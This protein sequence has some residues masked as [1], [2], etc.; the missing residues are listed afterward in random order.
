MRDTETEREAETQ[1]EGEAGSM[2]GA[3][4][5][6][7]SRVSRI[8]PWAEGST[9]PLSHPGCPHVKNLLQFLGEPLRKAKQSSWIKTIIPLCTEQQQQQQKT[10]TKVFSHGNSFYTPF[11]FHFKKRLFIWGWVSERSGRSRKRG[12]GKANPQADK[13]G[14]P[15]QDPEIMMWA[16]S[17]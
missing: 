13:Q 8:T 1:A 14:A 7:Q 2:Q 17:K 10:L 11:Y 15:S 5:G 3:W 6:T 16:E 4:C 12:R 9:K